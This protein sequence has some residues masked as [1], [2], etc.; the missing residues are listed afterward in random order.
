MKIG[1]T[2]D[3]HLSGFSQDI[4]D[5][6][7]NLPLRLAEK[8]KVCYNIIGDMKVR[9]CNT[10]IIAGDLLHNK[11]IIYSI[12]QS[13]LLN[14]IRRNI[15]ITFIVID[16]NHDLSGKGKN[17]V[18]SLECLDNEPNVIRIKKEGTI[19]ELKD[20]FFVP[21]SM[22]ISQIIK[23]NGSQYLVSHFGLDEALLNSGSSI[24]SDVSLKDLTGRYSIAFLGHYHLPQLIES[25]KVRFDG[26]SIRV[27]VPGSI[28]QTDWTEKN[29]DKR[30]IIFDTETEE[31]ES[32]ATVGYKKHFE[33]IIT[34]QNKIEVINQARELK[35][36]GDYVILKKEEEV[37][38]SEISKEFIIVD[39]TI[40]DISN[41]GISTSMSDLEKIR[42][43]EEIMKV[44][45]EDRSDTEREALDIIQSC[46]GQV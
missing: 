41:R 7:T 31:I 19:S 18:S 16:G 27:C 39:K 40:K 12:A 17:V 13:V 9:G 28:S 46:S 36:R 21:Y 20:F 29:E 14:F 23:N 33:L 22:E 43:Y 1:I 15:D 10:L 8:K 3:L 32:I 37:E 25:R 38:T 11:S 30:F 42:R 45:E 35:S 4:V 44:P 34:N 26:A 2:A 24:V 6:A 5:S